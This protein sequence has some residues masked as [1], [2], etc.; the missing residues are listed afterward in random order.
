MRSRT[1]SE[2]S[3]NL[4]KR[5]KN[6]LANFEWHNIKTKVFPEQVDIFSLSLLIH[7]I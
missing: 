3:N 1:L 7:E 6:K 5:L 4:L 2:L